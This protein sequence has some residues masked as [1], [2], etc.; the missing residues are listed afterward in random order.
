MT[1]KERFNYWLPLYGAVTGFVVLVPLLCQANLDVVYVFLVGPFALFA[2]AVALIV[3]A[4]RKR[5]R[6]LLQVLAILALFWVVTFLTAKNSFLIRSSAR[7]LVWSHGYKTE[8]LQQ[9]APAN[10]EFKHVRWETTGFAGVA[11][12]SVYLVFDPTDS[13][14]S[15]VKS[16]YAGKFNGIPRRVLHVRRLETHWYTVLFYTDEDWD[17]PKQ[18]CLVCD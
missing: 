12:D 13:L 11:V 6:Q 2:S 16:H 15:A 10:G 7:W 4:F 17:K 18:D 5:L 9:P 8:V 14:A 1:Q 3:A